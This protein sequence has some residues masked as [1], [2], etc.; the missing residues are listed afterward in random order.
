LADGPLDI[1]LS[2]AR[3]LDELG[4][5]YVLGGSLASSLVGQPRA[6]AD[7]DMAIRIAADQVPALVRALESEFYL[8][9]E[10]ARDAIRRSASFNLVHL[11][12]VQKVDLFVLGDGL[13]DR[14][15]LER[16]VRVRVR[17]DP[18]CELWIGSVADQV[19][20]KLSWYRAGGGVS[21]RQWRDVIGMLTVQRGRL[22]V[23]ELRSLA[24]EVD[25]D[26]LLDRALEEA[27]PKG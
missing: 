6:T 16:R 17:D 26:D 27:E 5:P 21:D 7:V 15:Q 11:E 8:S 23:N 2:V 24:A 3:T 12:S 1:T 9:E 22:D 18:P 4:I 20:R 10:A 14:R 13:L 25:L 19:L